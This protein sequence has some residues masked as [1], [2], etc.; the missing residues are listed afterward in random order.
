MVKRI[1]WLIVLWLAGVAAL[2]AVAT[3]LRFFMRLS[4]LSA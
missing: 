1:G 3:L 4:G 2:G